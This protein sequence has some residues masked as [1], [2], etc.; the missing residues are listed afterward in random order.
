MQEKSTFVYASYVKIAIAFLATFCVAKQSAHLFASCT[1]FSQKRLKLK[2]TQ[3]EQVV[4]AIG[5]VVQFII[6]TAKSSS[7]NGYKI[8]FYLFVINGG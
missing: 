4:K 8:Y 7:G 5:D 1:C 6:I 3:I 2:E